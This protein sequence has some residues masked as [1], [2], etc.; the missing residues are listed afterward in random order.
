MNYF[1]VL[2]D[3][4]SLFGFPESEQAF[5][6]RNLPFGT[7]LGTLLRYHLAYI[8]FLYKIDT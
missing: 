8:Y 2:I 7:V 6:N 3:V 5:W 4:P 1:V